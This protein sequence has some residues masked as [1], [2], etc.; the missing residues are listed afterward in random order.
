MI[1]KLSRYAAVD[2]ILR[3]KPQASILEIGA[4][5]H[6]LGCCLP[7]RFVG[8]DVSYPSPP[9]ETQTAIKASALRLPFPDRSFD[10]VL[11]IEVLEHI[12]PD[13]RA[14]IIT[15]LCRVS[16]DLVYLTHPYGRLARFDDHALR[17]IYGITGLFGKGSPEW[18]TEHL[19]FS[20]PDPK[21]YLP[22]VPN[23][24]TVKYT[25]ETNAILHPFL[26]FFFTI[27]V[28]SAWV[29]AR[30][31]KNPDRVM[32]CVKLT[33]FPPYARLCVMLNRTAQ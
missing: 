18:L 8:V 2:D 19:Q 20:Y 33:N 26:V 31:R 7:Y 14:N 5:P 25:K 22:A 4:G 21:R 9:V 23:G 24:Y 10:V 29:A 12:P 28:I 6:G 11:G 3:R 15:E 13:I 16:R 1:D 27:R 17:I 32:R 30:H